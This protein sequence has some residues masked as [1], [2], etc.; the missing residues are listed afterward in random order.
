MRHPNHFQDQ[1]RDRWRTTVRRSLLGTIGAALA[2]VLAAPPA[3]SFHSLMA[4]ARTE[5][6]LTDWW[7]YLVPLALDA[8]ALLCV[9]LATWAAWRGE[10]A[11]AARVL[12]WVFAGGSAAANARHGQAIG[13][14]DA[15][16]FF[17][18]LP[19]GAAVLLD[20][21][22]RR[23][24]RAALDD[25][26]A[27]EPPLP[28]YRLIRWAVAPRET[29]SAWRYAVRHGVTDPREALARAQGVPW[30][31]LPAGAFS[32]GFFARPADAVDEQLVTEPREQ[33]G[34]V[35]HAQ[36]DGPDDAERDPVRAAAAAYVTSTPSPSRRGLI[37]AVRAAG[38][39]I[40]TGPAGTLLR[41]L[42]TDPPRGSAA[43]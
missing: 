42:T 41:E 31:P 18:A 14:S 7:P 8:A 20:V 40:G 5:L 15:V 29:A 2:V 1:A 34:D 17:A 32:E 35:D 30:P 16:V 3:L 9:A 36:Q 12:V 23:A 13:T 25:I 33:L 6:A 21:V 22:L 4:W 10:A 24:R 27:L 38:H 11:G 28:R 37:A 26:G 39:G 43:A 19:V